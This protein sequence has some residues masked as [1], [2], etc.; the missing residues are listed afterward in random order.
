MMKRLT[1]KTL[2]KHFVLGKL[3]PKIDGLVSHKAAVISLMSKIYQTL[4]W[5]LSQTYSM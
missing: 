4:F 3:N 2:W 5:D 1:L